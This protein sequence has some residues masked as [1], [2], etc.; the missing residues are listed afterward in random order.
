[1][2]PRRKAL[3]IVMDGVGDRPVPAL[4]SKTPL[5]AAKTP[6]MDGLAKEG[7]TG[8]MDV[9]GPGLTPGSDAAHLALFGYDPVATYPGRGPLEAAGA[10]LETKRG[11]VAFRTNFAT[12]D[13]DM[14]VLDRRAGRDFTPEEQAALQSEIDGMEVDDVKLR[15][16]ATVEHRGALVLSGPDLY[17]EISDVDPHETGKK[18]L[19]CEPLQ[20]AA[21]KTA[22]VVNKMIRE[23]HKRIRDLPMNKKRKEEGLPP[24][25]IVLIRGP[26]RHGET[27]T[28]T[29]KYGIK[30]AVIAGGAL[31]IGTAKFVG[32][33]HVPVEGQTG[34]IDTSFE[35]IA[36]KTIECINGGYD[37]IFVH[38]KA[39]DNA[40]H[41]KNVEEKILAIERTDE[42]IG[43]ILKDTREEVV[44]AVTG[45]H[46]SPVS[47]GEHSSD[48]VP[49]LL[50]ADFLRPDDTETFSEIDAARGALHTIRGQDLLPLLLGYAGYIEKF[51]A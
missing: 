14:V 18:V 1:M 36:K 40:S 34:T 15:F 20:P 48:P 28:L 45:D 33:V 3:F 37:Y 8:L 43:Q 49:V 17:A 13:D 27:P 9:I 44:V 12:V 42:M 7:Q 11:D 31:Y 2:A 24:A 22:D 16:L 5:Q 38:I 35:N 4:K 25:N 26:G 30:A 10:G 47:L 51:G 41:D 29:E 23:I 21:K 46:S 50:W 32:M 19:K 39:T 6:V